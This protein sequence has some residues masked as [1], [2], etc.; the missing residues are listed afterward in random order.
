MATT[1]EYKVV[2][3]KHGEG[4]LGW[5]L[6]NAACTSPLRPTALYFKRPRQEPAQNLQACLRSVIPAQAGMTSRGA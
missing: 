3:L 6:V 2:T 5:E 1:W 4:A